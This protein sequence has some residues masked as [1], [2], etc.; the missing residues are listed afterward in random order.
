[1][2][3]MLCSTPKVLGVSNFWSLTLTRAG[4][5]IGIRNWKGDVKNRDGYNS[6]K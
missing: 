6:S 3:G 4:F 2:R 1:M 5:C